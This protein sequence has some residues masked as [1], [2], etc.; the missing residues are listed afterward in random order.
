MDAGILPLVIGALVLLAL[1]VLYGILGWKSKIYRF[2]I[3][4]IVLGLATYW[5]YPTY[6]WYFQ[7][8]EGTRDLVNI[9]VTSD[10]EVEVESA[11]LR[12]IREYTTEVRKSV[13]KMRGLLNNNRKLFRYPQIQV[14]E[15][16]TRIPAEL[17]IRIT[18]RYGVP[19]NVDTFKF[20]IDKDIF[21]NE[22][23]PESDI[24]KEKYDEITEDFFNTMEKAETYRNELFE[25]ERLKE[26]KRQTVTLGLDLAGG[27]SFTL[28]VDKD[29]LVS[30]VY[31]QYNH[32]LD[33]ERI[34]ESE[35]MKEFITNLEEQ[36]IEDIKSNFTEEE[37]NEVQQDII[38][39][40]E[41][42]DVNSTEFQNEVDNRLTTL[43][44]QRLELEEWQTKINQ[45]VDRQVKVLQEQ[46]EEDIQQ[47]IAFRQEQTK[48]DALDILKRRA[49]QFGVSEPEIGKTLGDRPLVQL[50]GADD[51][52]SARKMV[53][54]AGKLEF[55]LVDSNAMQ[56][57]RYRPNREGLIDYDTYPNARV[58]YE[59][60]N[61]LNPDANLDYL[62]E[63][64]RVRIISETG[65]PEDDSYA[66]MQGHLDKRG[67][68]VVEGWMF[69]KNNVE[70][71][72]KH[73]VNPRVQMSGGQQ[74][75]NEP[76]ISF[77]LDG[78]GTDIFAKVTG[79]NQ[80]ER[81]A[82]VLDGYIQSAPRISDRI[83]GRGQ[84]SGN[85]TLASAQDLVSILK[86]G[87]IQSKLKIVSEN[88]IGPKLGEENIKSG[89]MAT[90]IGLGLVMIF[91]LIWYKFGGLFA[92]IALVLNLFL[93]ISILSVFHF[94]LTLPGIAG[95]LLTI[96]MAVD[97]N[98]LIFERI[99][100]EIRNN[101]PIPV[102]VDEGYGKAFWTIF[103][104]NL[105]TI[106]AAIVL[107]QVG[108]G[109]LKGF[110]ITLA[111]GIASSMFT[112]LVIS[113]LLIDLLIT[114]TKGKK[115]WL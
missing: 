78:E 56:N 26:L 80:G 38:D 101:K 18:N 82:I 1:I 34:R 99:K 91:M 98:V 6:Q 65:N 110:G 104:A 54:Q 16:E 37:I 7:L 31:Q 28:D 17:D 2:I 108:T 49:N 44:E 79:E 61:E 11:R 42:T 21:K 88:V 100:E 45:A 20:D 71:Q 112:S 23:L 66:Y 13:D 90:M 85:F 89:L 81:L 102:A 29:E 10:E 87:T 92:D 9:P 62:V 33:P 67:Q 40:G 97:A 105:T 106:L 69:L 8:D 113:K 95:I 74:G 25:I 47:E 36:Y 114:I 55:R 57:L 107:S 93:L 76:F 63:A 58:L 48:R 4:I 39:E 72:G 109:V 96:G 59:R 3:I 70:M 46:A 14:P 75:F 5:I 64:D 43:A 60:L 50:P 32:R 53:T 51:P 94:T 86:S 30:D 35:E 41:I 22:I 111:I 15:D 83:V 27:I 68:R 12:S 103:D 77:E 24:E 52:A 73:I 19:L 115:L 84:I